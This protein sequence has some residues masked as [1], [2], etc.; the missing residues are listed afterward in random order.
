MKRILR[1]VISSLAPGGRVVVNLATLEN[2]QVAM[3]ALREQGIRPEVTQ[4]AVSRGHDV[5]GGL[6]HLAAFDP[7]FVVSA[8]KDG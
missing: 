5:G 2:L 3:E 7:V 4:V 8:E 6:T 1:E